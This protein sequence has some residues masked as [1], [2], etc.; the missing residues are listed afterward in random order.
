[1]IE[2]RRGEDWRRTDKGGCGM[3]WREEG[4][5]SAGGRGRVGGGEWMVGSQPLGSLVSD[6]RRRR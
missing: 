4:G 1:M 3:G 6:Q 2:E 5:R